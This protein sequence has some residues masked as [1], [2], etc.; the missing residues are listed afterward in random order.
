MNVRNQLKTELLLAVVVII[1]VGAIAHVLYSLPY[2]A[3]AQTN[4]SIVIPPGGAL[5]TGGPLLGGQGEWNLTVQN[6]GSDQVT[7][8]TIYV[9]SI[10]YTYRSTETAGSFSASTDQISP[11]QSVT[12]TIWITSAQSEASQSAFIHFRVVTVNGAVATAQVPNPA[13]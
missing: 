5:V 4:E 9:D 10:A 2:Q 8:A 13:F 7:I 1:A 11:G 6:T 12:F 3:S